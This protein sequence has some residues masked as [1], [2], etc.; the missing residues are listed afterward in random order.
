MLLN[1]F[2]GRFDR[3]VVSITGCGGKTSLMWALARRMAAGGGGKK[4][5]VTTTT[6]TQSPGGA[7]GLF[8]YFF[9]ETASASYGLVPPCGIG[10]AGNHRSGFSVSSLT[11]PALERV[12]PLFDRVFIEADGSRSKPLKAWASYEP[13]ITESTTVTVG[14]L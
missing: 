12:I 13:V 9:D 3:T 4:T 5:L 10:F 1:D 6:H 14:I 11:L 7:S 8:D 2:F